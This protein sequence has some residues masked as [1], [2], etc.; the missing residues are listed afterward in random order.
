VSRAPPALRSG[1]ALDTLISSEGTVAV[2]I[3]GAMRSHG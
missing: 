2:A 1:F 3:D